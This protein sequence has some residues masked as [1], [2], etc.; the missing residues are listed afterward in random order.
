MAML[1]LVA[2]Q[3]P[4]KVQIV[5]V[6]VVQLHVVRTVQKLVLEDVLQIVIHVLGRVRARY[7]RVMIFVQVDAVISVTTHVRT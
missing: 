1:A 5:P 7:H 4:E 2:V 3:L 6:I